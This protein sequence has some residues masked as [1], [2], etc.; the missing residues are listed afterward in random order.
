MVL[1]D[2]SQALRRR[3]HPRH[4]RAGALPPHVHRRR[5]LRRADR[6]GAGPRHAGPVVAPDPRHR[7]G[8]HGRAAQGGDPRGPPAPHDHRRLRRVGD[9]RHGLRRP[10][11]GRWRRPPSARAPGR[12]WCPTTAP[13]SSSRATTSSGGPLAG[14]GCRSATW[15]TRTAPRRRSRSSTASGWRCPATGPGT[16]ADGTIELLGRDSMVVNTGGE[17]VFVEEVEGVLREHPGV[18]DALVVGRPSD[19]FG[20]EVVAVV[21]PVDGVVGVAGRAAG[22]RRRAHRPVQGAAGRAAVRR[23]APPHQR[24]GRLPLGQG[25]RVDAVDATGGP[26]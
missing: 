24:Q 13:G 7:R 20:Q 8:V 15:T 12:P 6:R 2:D 21:S 9:R 4:R 17:K 25:G 22:V 16:C 19:R 5:R 26:A 23:G 3:G 11:Q 14:A 10:P 18:S 1:H